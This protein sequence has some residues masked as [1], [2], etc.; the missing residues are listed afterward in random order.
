[1]YV[2][3]L[4]C[5][6]SEY[7]ISMDPAKN[8]VEF[9]NPRQVFDL[10]QKTIT[11]FLQ[12]QGFLSKSS[13]LHYGFMPMQVD[14]SLCMHDVEGENRPAV[15]KEPLVAPSSKRIRLSDM[16]SDDLDIRRLMKPR[17]LS[18]LPPVVAE[19]TIRH[20]PDLNDVHDCGR[21]DTVVK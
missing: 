17:T 21:D 1:M 20:I 3:M 15:E 6:S 7:D 9:R 4:K 14:S 19:S 2:I 12:A 16:T 18:A 8:I 11:E 5:A 10:V 13:L